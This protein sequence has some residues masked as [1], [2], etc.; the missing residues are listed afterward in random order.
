MRDYIYTTPHN[1]VCLI[2]KASEVIDTEIT[3]EIA[4][5]D[6]PV[7]F[8]VSFRENSCVSLICQKL[9]VLAYIPAVEVW[10]YLY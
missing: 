1:N 2:S 6:H 10:V 8:D 5:F 3:E 7:S 4:F 9:R